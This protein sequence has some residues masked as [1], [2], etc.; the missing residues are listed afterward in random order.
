MLVFTEFVNVT[1][2]PLLT[3]ETVA[4]NCDVPG[5]IVMMS[6]ACQP[7]VDPTV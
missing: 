2:V 6:P 3:V 1:E 4:V 5:L 7:D